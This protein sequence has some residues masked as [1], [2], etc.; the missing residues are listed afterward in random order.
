MVAESQNRDLGKVSG[1][2]DLLM[3]KLNES[4]TKTIVVNRSRTKHPQSP[5]LNNGG[6]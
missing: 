2:S 6:D 3:M 4:K 1:E 5:P